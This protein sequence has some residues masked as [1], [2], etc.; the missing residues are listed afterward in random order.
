VSI[1]P[2]YNILI[3]DYLSNAVRVVNPSTG[4]ISTIAGTGVAGYSGD[5][6]PATAAKV[7]QP[8][9]AVYQLSTSNVY[10]SDYSNNRIRNIPGVVLPIELLNFSATLG[11]ENEV[12]LKWSTASETNNN[13]FEV[14][15][16]STG[17]DFKKVGTVKG[18][19]NSSSVLHYNML[20]PNPTQGT[21]YYRL[22][23]VDFNG[24]YTYFAPVAVNLKNDDDF[25]VFPNPSTRDLPT[26]MRYKSSDAGEEILVVLLDETGREVYSKVE[27][28]DQTGENLIAV[29]GMSK[30][31]PG[32]Y[33]ISASSS[34]AIYRRK[35]IIR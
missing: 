18:A 11:K 8:L 25:T 15:Q 12:D 13:F 10:I 27:I 9:Q 16:S 28:I 5:G 33:F 19:G 31:H 21:S 6:G 1:D 20:D 3:A 2:N 24:N 7:N 4:F 32:L 29:D 23:Q 17:K 22:K 35:L 30:L 34:Q 14:E 26:F